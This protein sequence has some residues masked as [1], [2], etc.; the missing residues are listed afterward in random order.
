MNRFLV[1]LGIILILL[2]NKKNFEKKTFFIISLILCIKNQEYNLENNKINSINSINKINR[3]D[4]TY[5]INI[6]SSNKHINNLSEILDSV[7]KNRKWIKLNTNEATKLDRIGFTLNNNDT[8]TVIKSQINYKIYT[9]QKYIFKNNIYVKEFFEHTDFFCDYFVLNKSSIVENIDYLYNYVKDKIKNKYNSYLILKDPYGN[10]DIKLLVFNHKNKTKKY[11]KYIINYL[12]SFKSQ[13]VILEKYLDSITFK[14][15]ELSFNHKKTNYE[16]EF[17]R[18]SMIRFFIVVLVRNNNIEI[19]KINDFIIYLTTLPSSENIDNDINNIGSY[20]TSHY[21]N[22]TDINESN[23]KYKTN[24]NT[25]KDALLAKSHEYENEILTK[26]FRLSKDEFKNQYADKFDIL[27]N[28]ID[29]FILEFGN[30]Y[31]S[32]F[33]CKNDKCVNVNFNSCF[34]IFSIDTIFT[35]SD[36]LKILHINNNPL[37]MSLNSFKK[38][39][40]TFNIINI[41]NDIFN[42]IESDD[43]NTGSLKLICKYDRNIDFDKIYYLS[44]NQIQTYPEIIKALK[45]RNYTR[46]IWKKKDINIDMFLGYIIKNNSLAEDDKDLYLNYLNRFLGNYNI[47]NKISGAVFELGDKSLLYDHLKNTKIISDYVNFKIYRD[48]KDINYIQ[49]RDL[50]NIEHFININVSTCS[51]FIL[52]PSLG[53]QGDGIEVIKYYEQFQEWYKKEKKY[54]E[55]SISEFLTPKLLKSIKLN[56]NLLRKNHIRSYFIIT[57]NSNLDIKIY[58]LKHRIIYF[59]VDKYITKCVSVNKENKYSFI[60]NLALASEERNINY[61]TRNYSDDLFNY[62]DQIFN[63]KKLSDLITSYG[64]ECIEILNKENLKCFNENNKKFKGCYQILAID[65]LPINKNNLKV[66]EVNRGPGFK[67]LKVNFNLEDI[68]NE[69]FM[70]SVDNFNGI[71]YNDEDLKLLTRLK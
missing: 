41:F 48:G 47:T 54:T 61:D 27:N 64:L 55:W 13:Y 62:Q 70:I 43:K 60:T 12:N 1:S 36:Q 40:N 17:G 67:G 6:K 44:I 35:K 16:T 51:R 23:K 50:L 45:K 24:I 33:I 7:L 66:L 20:V 10:S 31:N 18:R 69:I 5:Y 3:I 38:I 14:V 8:E 19:Y 39:K 52:K 37:N 59:A 53:S 4:K 28:K 32:E 68:F 42:I 63:F 21:N 58:E 25:Y 11:K 56:D 26:L 22:N 2:N 34:R 30:T 29:E 57:K 65:Y 71:N 9:Q 15:P 49:T 46:S